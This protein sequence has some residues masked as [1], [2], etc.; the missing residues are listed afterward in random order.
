MLAATEHGCW[1]LC[2]PC[3]T[4]LFARDLSPGAGG[5]RGRLPFLPAV[6]HPR[7]PGDGVCV[8]LPFLSVSVRPG[9]AVS[10]G[11]SHTHPRQVLRAECS[12]VPVAAENEPE[13]PE[14]QEGGLSP[15][16]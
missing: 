11:A 14:D 6:P 13:K 3:V 2:A 9:E 16:T 8:L 12:A 4:F 15:A 10:L 7:P 1:V 5:G